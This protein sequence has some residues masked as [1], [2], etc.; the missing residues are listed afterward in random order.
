M[1]G[2]DLGLQVIAFIQQGAILW[3]ELGHYISQ[4]IPEGGGFDA[5]A[6]GNVLDQFNQSTI[7]AEAADI[8]AIVHRAILKLV[9]EPASYKASIIS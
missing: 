3:T 1:P 2:I 7:N 8:D 4:R 5:A 6:F 9:A